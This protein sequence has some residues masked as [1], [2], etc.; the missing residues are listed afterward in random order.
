MDEAV[1]SNNQLKMQSW[2]GFKAPPIQVDKKKL[3]FKAIAVAGATDMLGNVVALHTVDSAITI[4]SFMEFLDKV[5]E[6]TRHRWCTLFLDNLK[7]HYNW[8][9]KRRAT[10]NRIHLL[11]NSTYS[12]E[13]N[14]IERLWAMSKRTFAK[15]AI[16]SGNYQN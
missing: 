9:V 12:S 14:P 5:R 1:F 13:F 11:F 8:Q 4:E 10:R 7:L 6:Y 2:N 3:S 15:A 16:C